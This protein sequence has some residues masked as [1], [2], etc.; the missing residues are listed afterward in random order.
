MLLY[1]LILMVLVFVFS[2]LLCLL[3]CMNCLG[4]TDAVKGLINRYTRG[5]FDREFVANADN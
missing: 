3:A 2:T 4:L 1:I 5:S